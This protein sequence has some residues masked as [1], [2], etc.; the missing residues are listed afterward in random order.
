VSDQSSTGLSLQRAP[1]SKLAET[2]A[3]QLLDEINTKQLP[4]GTRM[5][6][7][8][9]LMAALGVGRS[10][11][12][13]AVNGLAMLGV[14]EIRHGQGAFVVNPEPP[15]EPHHA[16]ATALARGVTE[17]LTEARRLVEVESAGLAAQ[18]R[19]DADLAE[20]AQTLADHAQALAD[21]TPAVQ[22]SVQFHLTIAQATHNE[23]LAG[24]VASFSGALAARGPV[25]EAEPGFRE[26]ELEQHRSVFAPIAAGD[27]DAA[28]AAMAAHLEAVLPYHERIGPGDSRPADGR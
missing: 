4:A 20:I 2:V 24:F 14:L 27:A 26:W 12:R 17:D 3:R 28:R 8:R 9:E 13:E 7:E 22:P 15:A 23:V 10:T 5:P 6:S 19:T 18:R 21:G 25:L 16:L 1:R 11:I